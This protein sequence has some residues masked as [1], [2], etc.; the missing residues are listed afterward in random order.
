MRPIGPESRAN[1]FQ[2]RRFLPQPSRQA[3]LVEHQVRQGERLDNIT[4]RYLADP[5]QAYRVY[6][7][8][9]ILH[10]QELLDAQAVNRRLRI[11]MPGF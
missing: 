1:A 7:A 3:T 11:A 4:A 6:D 8:N 9:P 10:P 2:R 5:L